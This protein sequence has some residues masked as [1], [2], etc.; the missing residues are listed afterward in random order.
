MGLQLSCSVKN[1]SAVLSH[2]FIP[3]CAL[4]STGCIVIFSHGRQWFHPPNPREAVE[5]PEGSPGEAAGNTASPGSSLCL[6]E[7]RSWQAA[8]ILNGLGTPIPTFHLHSLL[9][10]L[11][12]PPGE[13]PFIPP[14]LTAWKRC[15]HLTITVSD[16]TLMLSD[17]IGTLKMNRSQHVTARI[18]PAL[19]FFYRDI[20]GGFF[21]SGPGAV[22]FVHREGIYTR[23]CTLIVEPA[24]FSCN[25]QR[26][27][28]AHL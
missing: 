27:K 17:G 2:L 18:T 25:L 15:P 8:G 13:T 11:I 7:S 4:A 28:S 12:L 3:S 26:K 23:H 24:S 22:K 6:Q 1:I 20:L 16:C 14:L 10:F 5:C 19:P 9:L 21:S